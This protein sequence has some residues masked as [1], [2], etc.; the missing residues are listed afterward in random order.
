M[1]THPMMVALLSNI[2][3]RERLTPQVLMSMTVAFMGLFMILGD[4]LVL[5]VNTFGILLALA[6][7]ISYS[8][9]IFI[10]S[11]VIKKVPS[12]VATAY[13]SVSAF[14]GL[15]GLGMAQ[16]SLSLNFDLTVWIPLTG[17]VFCS[18]IFALLFFL[19]G[20]EI[21]GATKSTIISM[22]EP[23][24]AVVFSMIIFKEGLSFLQLIGGIAVLSG[25]VMVM[26]MK[27]S[28][29][30]ILLWITI[31]LLL[32]Q[33]TGCSEQNRTEELKLGRYIRQD[34]EPVAWSWISLE[35]NE[36][37]IFNR[38]LATSYLPMGTYSVEGNILTLYVNTNESYIFRID[39]NKLVFKRGNITGDLIKEGAVFMLSNP[40]NP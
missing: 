14:G 18:T 38:S 21:L 34:T 31:V 30:F 37:F 3:D 4:S 9:Y 17:L 29:K 10:S 13:I 6:T 36:K 19:R 5:K 24:F 8:L 26:M 15:L 7:A 27:E 20:V 23:V 22:F 2:F 12:L 16:G 25:A 1:Y 40:S 33:V 35:E 28:R 39:G 11:R 32:L